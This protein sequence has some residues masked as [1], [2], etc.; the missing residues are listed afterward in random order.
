M[1]GRC[2]VAVF[3]EQ[4]VED[5]AAGGGDVEGVLGAE[6]RDADVSVA[7]GQDVGLDAVDFVTEDDTDGEARAPIEEVDGVDGGFDGGDFEVAVSECV[8]QGEGVPGVL[9]RNRFFGAEGR[10]GDCLF[11]RTSGDAGE[12][13]LFET[14]CVGG[15]EE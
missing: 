1:L 13:E 2:E 3:A 5:D 11:G 10:F 14:D 8:E 6:H 7:T 9:P 4:F 12:E 15:A